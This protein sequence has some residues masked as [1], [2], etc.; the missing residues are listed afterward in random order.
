LLNLDLGSDLSCSVTV[1]GEGSDF[2]CVYPDGGVLKLGV[3][4]LC[5]DLW[6]IDC[7]YN[8][9]INSVIDVYVL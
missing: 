8:F 4:V 2:V 1:F 7:E 6:N 9:W 5:G 3:S